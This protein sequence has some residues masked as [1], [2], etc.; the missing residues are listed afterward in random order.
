MHR[1]NQIHCSAQCR[2][3]AWNRRN[4][5]LPVKDVPA[6]VLRKINSHRRAAVAA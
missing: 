4:P 6:A 5:H 2:W 1:R 3:Q